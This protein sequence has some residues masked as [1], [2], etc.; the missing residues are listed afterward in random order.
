MRASSRGVPRPP[1]VGARDAGAV[2]PGERM[3]L[4]CEGGPSMSR[5][6]RYPPPLEVAVEGGVY[7]LVDDGAPQTWHYDFIALPLE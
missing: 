3:L 6:E 2:E 5:L 4:P 1:M 7:V